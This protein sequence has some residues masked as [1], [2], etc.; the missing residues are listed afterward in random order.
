V[1]AECSEY[2]GIDDAEESADVRELKDCHERRGWKSTLWGT[3]FP[4]CLAIMRLMK[5]EMVDMCK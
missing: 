5:Y 4:D 2:V 3:V 1:R